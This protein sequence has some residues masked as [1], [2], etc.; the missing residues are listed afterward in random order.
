[1]AASM[2]PRTFG[3]ACSKNPFS[4]PNRRAAI[5]AGGGSA[6][7]RR[8]AITT[9]ASSADRVSGP[10]ESK[11]SDAGKM[12]SIG[13]EP[14]LVLTPTTPQKAAGIGAG[15]CRHTVD[16]EQILDGYWHAHERSE[17]NAQSQE[18]VHIASLAPRVVGRH[19]LVGTQRAVKCVN[20]GEISVGCR[21]RGDRTPSQT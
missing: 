7:P 20:P 11:D 5:G 1:M 13:H 10:I 16:G 8:Q 3:S 19:V 4:F 21:F 9:A 12:P 14:T 2:H 18:R 17:I 6:A 15:R